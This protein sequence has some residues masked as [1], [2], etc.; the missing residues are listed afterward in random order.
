MAI[1]KQFKTYVL[2]VLSL[3]FFV[4]TVLIIRV[5]YFTSLSETVQLTQHIFGCNI[6]IRTSSFLVFW[7]LFAFVA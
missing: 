4:I 7:G 6:D 1:F 2:I 3:K 5:I